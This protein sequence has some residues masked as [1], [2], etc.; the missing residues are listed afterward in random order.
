MTDPTALL[1]KTTNIA[2]PR[3]RATRAAGR[4]LRVVLAIAVAGAG[5]EVWVY[6]LWYR[7][8]EAVAGGWVSHLLIGTSMAVYRPQATF[9]LNTGTRRAFGITVSPECTSATVTAL[10]LVV[11]AAVMIV[12][13]ASV[14]RSITAAVAAAAT[15]AL[16]NLI[17]LVII[18]TS[19]DLWGT[20]GGLHW[21]HVWAGTFI[22]V[23]VGWPP[24]PST[25]SPSAPAPHASGAPIW[26]G[27]DH[28]R[29]RNRPHQRRRR[30]SSRRA[31]RHRRN[32]RQPRLHRISGHRPGHPR[33]RT[34]PD[35][36]CPGPPRRRSPGATCHRGGSRRR[37]HH[38]P[39]PTFGRLTTETS[40]GVD[41][42]HAPPAVLEQAILDVTPGLEDRF[43]NAFAEANTL[44]AAVPG[45]RSLRL[46]R[47]IETPSRYLYLVEWDHPGVLTRN[48]TAGRPQLKHE[49]N[50]PAADGPDEFRQSEK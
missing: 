33:R 4:I 38:Q 49:Q 35:R 50:R 46:A 39:Q 36:A 10:I 12:G 8:Y 48:Q 6:R 3:G 31:R 2:A 47:S 24:L 22:T 28:V 23:S 45:F 32:R 18:A 41:A 27:A 5:V 13:G 16:C 26:Q 15:F 42:Q 19:T 30:A 9:F 29:I 25:S 20:K 17:R 1:G 43:E 37:W 44:L 34:D 21:S 40:L 14:R 7:S 11:T